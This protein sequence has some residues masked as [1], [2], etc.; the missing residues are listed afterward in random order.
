MPFPVLLNKCEKKYDKDIYSWNKVLVF[1]L[2]FDK[3]L[4]NLNHRVTKRNIL[5]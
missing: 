4:I 5:L 2:G 1:N 3:E